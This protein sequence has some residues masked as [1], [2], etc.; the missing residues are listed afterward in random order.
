M[1]EV[2]DDLAVAADT[3]A[4]VEA[5][6]RFNAEVDAARAAAT[7]EADLC[8][9]GGA[10][11]L[12]AGEINESEVDGLFELKDFVVDQEYPGD[13]RLDELDRSG[14]LRVGRLVQ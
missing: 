6:E 11:F 14:R 5:S 4:S 8:L 1:Y 10:P 12:K 9:A 3:K 13:V 2:V 7:V